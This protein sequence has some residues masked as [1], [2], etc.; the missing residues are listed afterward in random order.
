M[1]KIYT[2]GGDRGQTS[3]FSGDRVSKGNLLVHA[4]GTVD[5][6]NCVLGV[7]RSMHRRP[8]RLAEI[9][10]HLQNLLF[11]AGADLASGKPKAERITESQV[12]EM[13]QF[14]DELTAGLS[15]LESF[16][17]PAGHPVAAHLHQARTVCR[18]AERCTVQA[19]EKIQVDYVLVR[20]LN[21]LADLLFVMAREANR[22]HGE[23]EEQ[24]QAP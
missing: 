5:E 9:L 24:W 13:E 4:Y 2:K 11:L 20:F 3:L 8:D 18:R 6:L 7:V 1:V 12:E 19:M 14:I 22:V 17:L 23:R 16:I 15:P 21:R 10:Y